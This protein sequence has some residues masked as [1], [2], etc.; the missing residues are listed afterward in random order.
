MDAKTQFYKGSFFV[1][2]LLSAFISSCDKESAEP[3]VD[4]QHFRTD[5]TKMNDLVFVNGRDYPVFRIKNPFVE[6]YQYLP[7]FSLEVELQPGDIIHMTAECEVTNDNDYEVQMGSGVAISEEELNMREVVLNGTYIA[8]LTGMNLDNKIIHHLL[9]T[10][11]GSLTIPEGIS[12]KR[13]IHFI[14]YAVSDGRKPDDFLLLE[15]GHL[16]ITLIRS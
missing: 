9:M 7:M 12:G 4:I 6:N 14:G 2:L 13:W 10:R 15:R 5:Q 16:S 3:Q 1:L 8:G 11:A